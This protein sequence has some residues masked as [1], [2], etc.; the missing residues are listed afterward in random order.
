SRFRTRRPHH[1]NAILGT[2]RWTIHTA[3]WS[4]PLLQAGGAAVAPLI[5]VSYGSMAEIGGGLFDVRQ[6]YGG[7]DFWSVTV[8][9]RL[10]YGGGAHRMGRYG[11][12]LEGAP[13]HGH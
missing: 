2:T 4:S 1:E 13:P 11:A 7:D 5:E 10:T 12:A 6:A 9:A 8:G 3:G